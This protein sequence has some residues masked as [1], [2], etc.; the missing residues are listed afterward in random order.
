MKALSCRSE[1]KTRGREVWEIHYF[2]WEWKSSEIA[3]TFA[4]ARSSVYLYW[5]SS[6]V[7]SYVKHFASVAFSME[8][9][10]L[11]LTLSL[12]LSRSP[13]RAFSSSS[14]QPLW[15]R[16]YLYFLCKS[17]P[18]RG[19][20][21]PC[22]TMGQSGLKYTKS[23]FISTII[24]LFRRILCAKSGLSLWPAPC[25]MIEYVDLEGGC[26]GSACHLSLDFGHTELNDVLKFV[27]H[28]LVQLIRTGAY[29]WVKH[30]NPWQKRIRR[31]PYSSNPAEQRATRV[32]F[33]GK[34]LF[35]SSI[36]SPNCFMQLPFD[37]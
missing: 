22:H 8:R 33:P 28:K 32:S 34:V 12:R 2:T 18:P 30:R 7:Q 17:R 11:S 24:P 35:N 19:S 37:K 1:M 31:E 3:S 16:V 15:A 29:A 26:C 27:H 36:L 9:K 4:L 25:V 6:Q 13:R 21:A 20:V 5:S 14:G 23:S 10:F